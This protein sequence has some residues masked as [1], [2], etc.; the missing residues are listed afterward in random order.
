MAYINDR[1]LTWAIGLAAVAVYL[2][3]RKLMRSLRKP[4]H[5]TYRCCRCR[6]TFR[7]DGRTINAWRNGYRKFFCHDCHA[8]WRDRREAVEVVRN[9]EYASRGGCL[10]VLFLI[11]AIA[12]LLGKVG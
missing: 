5:E 10:G 11:V 3:I 7:H 8:D 6:R 1:M 4:P 2:L 12:I 9:R